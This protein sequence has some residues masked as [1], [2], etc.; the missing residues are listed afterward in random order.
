[1]Y[2][3]NLTYLKQIAD[4]EKHIEAHRRYLDENYA[5]EVF[6][7]SGPKT[8]RDGGLILVSGSIT[9]AELELLLTQ[10]PFF[11]HEIASYNVTEF[12]PTKFNSALASLV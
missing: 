7:A 8:P 10:D 11:E 4:V 2:I 9:R 12:T 5:R 6:L 3:V 1:M